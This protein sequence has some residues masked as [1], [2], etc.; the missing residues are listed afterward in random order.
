MSNDLA[1]CLPIQARSVAIT[2][3]AKDPLV[4]GSFG[5]VLINQEPM[6]FLYAETNYPHQI[7]MVNAADGLDLCQEFP[8]SLT[9]SI[10]PFHRDFLLA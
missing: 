1:S 5:H 4:Q 2:V 7:D 10:Q 9:S 3:P 8:L 6:R